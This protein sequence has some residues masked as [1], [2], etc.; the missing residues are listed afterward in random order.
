MKRKTLTILLV[1][2]IIV[3][4]VS[5][6]SVPTSTAPVD[7]PTSTTNLTP[8]P[9]PS[10]EDKCTEV[11]IGNL[12]EMKSAGTIVLEDAHYQAYT[13]NAD[14]F[15][16]VELTKE[17]EFVF[18]IATSPNRQLTAY[19]LY[20]RKNDVSNLI[21]MDS[22]GVTQFS[23]PWEGGWNFISSWLD[24][25]RLLINIHADL[26]DGDPAAKEFSTF[27]AA[28]TFTGEKKLLQPDFPNIYSHHMFPAWDGFGSTVYNAT[29]DRV[30]YLKEDVA[31]GSFH[32]I[33]WDINGQ[34]SLADFKV[35]VNGQDIPHWSPDGEKFAIAFSLVDDS[36]NKWLVS[37]LYT[38]SRDGDVVKITDLSK[39]YSWFYIGQHS[40]SP[41]GRYI[42]FWFSEWTEPPQISG[43][44]DL[45]ANQHLAIVDTKNND[46]SIYCISG[47]SQSN[48]IV[49]PPV[50]SPDGHQILI[51]TP[52][53]DEYS[54]VLLL[55]LNRN[56]FTVIGKDLTPVGWMVKP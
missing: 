7:T 11:K 29:L 44:S 39:Y 27:L 34:R 26:S 9:I 19:N 52:L 2:L 47:K 38:V 4:C 20:S 43:L 42:A 37:N 25:Q 51:E 35:F 53:P 41:D 1:L 56:V 13:I 17:D 32:Y 36:S 16:K 22:S 49:P 23:I 48:G 21:I 14:T 40:W 46:L 50:W 45:N 12:D 30:V 8:T 31:D 10:S 15:E 24:N 55:D 6:T 3:G 5:N 54:Q 33:L 18:S 28:N